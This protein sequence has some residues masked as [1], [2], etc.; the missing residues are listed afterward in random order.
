MYDEDDLDF[1]ERLSMA[2]ANE[3][4]EISRN[5]EKSIDKSNPMCYNMNELKQRAK[6]PRKYF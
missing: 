5:L 4:K 6:Q 1:M 2:F 3:Q